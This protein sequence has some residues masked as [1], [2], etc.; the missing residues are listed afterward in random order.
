M[1]AKGK[2][3]VNIKGS[4]GKPSFEISIVRSDNKDG[5]RSYGWFDESKLLV[6]HSGGSCTWTVTREIWNGLIELAENEAKRLNT[7]EKNRR[8]L[9][10][11]NGK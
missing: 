2:W 9:M 6:S 4:F 10:E 3:I 8:E 5:I 11:D 1:K 7:I